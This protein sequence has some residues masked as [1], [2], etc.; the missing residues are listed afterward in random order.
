MYGVG[1]PILFPIAAVSYFVFWL[2]ERY[3]VA[4]TYPMPPAMDDR[5]VQNALSILSYAPILLL[6]NGYWMLSNK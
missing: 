6:I 4:Y 3:Q 1:M 5:M 2:V